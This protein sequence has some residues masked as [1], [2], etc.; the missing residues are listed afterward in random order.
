MSLRAFQMCIDGEWTPAI[1]GK[2]FE[3][4][5][6]A[7][8]Q[9]WATFPDA[10]RDDVEKAVQ[11]AD[12]AF[13]SD[14]WRSINATQRGKMLRKLGDLIAENSETLAQ[15]ESTDNG[16]LIRETRGQVS[17]LPEFF[18][19]T[20][21]LADKLEGET[22]PLDKTDMMA[23]TLYEPIGVVAAIIPWNSPLYLTAIKLAPA[24][25]AG[26]TLVLKP[27]EHASATLAELVRLVHEAGFP[28]GVVNLVTGYGPGTGSALTCHPL[29]RKIAFT[30]GAATARHVIRSSAD[31]FAKLSLELGGKSPQ[32]VFADA[33]LTSAMN[34]IVA[35]IFA[36]SGQSCVAG[37]RILVQRPVYEQF[38]EQL[39]ERAARIQIGHPR[40]DS[41]EMGPMATAQQLSV[42][43]GFVEAAKKEGAKLRL[44]GERVMHP[45][46]GWYFQPT[47]F[48]CRSNQDYLMQ[49][50]VFGPVA[51]V[52]P[53]DDEADALAMA[54][55]S[56]YG[57]AAGIWTRDLARAHRLARSVHSGI[58][59]V[60]TYRAVSAMASIG[61]YK[62]SG[63][64]RESGIDSVRA[65]TEKKT[66][67]INLS[68]EPMSD[69][70]V[71]R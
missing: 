2:T 37:S 18:Y 9:P 66:V 8:T 21:G 60:N 49:E 20:A 17:Y 68:S 15:L 10:D 46:G 31:N 45:D 1:S 6:P 39:A 44:G 40:D 23:Y 34:G 33:D 43:E 67:W 30:G 3:S 25:A 61:G 35:G 51:A 5:D 27:S 22:L 65:F 32:I 14:E 56:Q 48:E 58:I 54:N 70:F 64:G 36:A 38:V 26:N 12:R 24:L 47:I 16:K 59:W 19:Y 11:A 69:P 28:N 50:E 29:V 42:V 63:Y 55:D 57:L 4:L 13:H 53:F 62:H 52:I 41:S 7:T 71:M